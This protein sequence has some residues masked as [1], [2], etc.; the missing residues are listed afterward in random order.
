LSERKCLAY[1]IK[2][3]DDTILWFF[4]L[5]G[6]GLEFSG[7]MLG[8]FFKGRVKTLKGKNSEQVDK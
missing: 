1:F 4:Y 7:S 8:K 2:S 5:I 6:V 3:Y